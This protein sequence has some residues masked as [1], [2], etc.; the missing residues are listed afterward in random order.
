MNLTAALVLVALAVL[1]GLAVHGWWTARRAAPRKA[2]PAA[3]PA[4]EERVE[5]TLGALGAD[6]ARPAATALRRGARIDPLIDAV[7]TLAVEAPVSGET[8]LAHLPSTRRAGAK[9]F[10]VEGLSV[11]S[12]D[13]EAPAA[14]TRYGEL[15]AGVQLANRS[16]ALNEIEYSEF[17]QKIQAFADAIGA[18]PDFPD[19]LDVVARA[20][21]LDAFAGPNDAN[22]TVC[23]RSNSVAWSVGYVRQCAERHG[24]VPGTLPGRL[25]MPSPEEGAPPVLVLS[26]DAQAALSDDPQLAAVRQ[27]TLALDV[28]QTPES[29][30][31]FAAWQQ[32]IRA[33][34]DDMDATAVDDDGRPITLQHY[35][36]I[37]GEL[38]TLYRALEARD[39]AAGSAVARRL[40]Q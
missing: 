26:F 8:V 9:P 16:G 32:A 5:P 40:F 2:V 20:R 36:T 25:V 39:M 3:A 12:G 6:P 23:L 29:A 30:E 33:L 34:C 21:E 14:N 37:A 15:Q 10:H 7:A 24:F 4:T 35:A 17:V 22:L 19:M 27:L 13:W 31:P 18:A 28:A 11:D 1:A 38:Q